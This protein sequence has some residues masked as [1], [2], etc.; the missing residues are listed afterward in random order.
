MAAEFNP[1]RFWGEGP[2]LA[3]Q[4]GIL[5]DLTRETVARA[6][7]YLG[8]VLPNSYIELLKIKNGGDTKGFVIPVE[9]KHKWV[10]DH[11]DVDHL[12]GIGLIQPQPPDFYGWEGSNNIYMSPYMIREWGLPERQI[13]LCGD[14]H[15]WITLDY[16]RGPEPVVTWLDN[17]AGPEFE[18]SVIADS[19]DDFL[20][21]LLPLDAVDP[22]T[23]LLKAR[24]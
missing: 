22:E 19:F 11:L 7:A 9:Y 24:D 4:K 12:N 6:E 21:K 2:P 15:T 5:R 16:R 8:I 20:S 18:D 1:T 14:G 13:M 10:G 23:M 3:E 17:D